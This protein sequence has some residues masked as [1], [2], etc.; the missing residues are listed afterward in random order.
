MFPYVCKI[1]HLG[2]VQG[3]DFHWS[4]NLALRRAVE[5]EG[6]QDLGQ[7]GEGRA[8]NRHR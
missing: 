6:R 4:S 8:F 5:V 3:L 1:L 2:S 7:T